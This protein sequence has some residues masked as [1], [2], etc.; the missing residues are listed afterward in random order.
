MYPY[1]EYFFL[2]NAISSTRAATLQPHSV[3][4]DRK[5]ADSRNFCTGSRSCKR[6]GEAR[7][8]YQRLFHRYLTR[9]LEAAEIQI[10]ISSR[11]R[12]K[13]NAKKEVG[14]ESTPEM[15][16]IKE[17]PKPPYLHAQTAR[18][19]YLQI[20]TRAL[21]NARAVPVDPDQVLYLI[22]SIITP[23]LYNHGIQSASTYSFAASFRRRALSNRVSV[24]P[25]LHKLLSIF[26]HLQQLIR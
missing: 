16:T 4:R 20:A 24:A 3:P 15:S 23:H 9:R 8:R 17:P 18:G 25:P 7:W 26:H 6:R 10:A 19:H 14:A 2:D 12:S 22:R 21:V 1:P 11:N 13:P 5:Q